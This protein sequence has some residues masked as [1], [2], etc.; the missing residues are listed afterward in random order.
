MISIDIHKPYIGDRSGWWQL[1]SSSP[2]NHIFPTTNQIK[3]KA[4]IIFL[5]LPACVSNLGLLS[6]KFLN[7]YISRTTT[8]YMAILAAAKVAHTL[9]FVSCSLSHICSL[10]FQC[11]DNTIMAAKT[12]GKLTAMIANTV[13]RLDDTS[14]ILAA[15]PPKSWMFWLFAL[16]E[17]N[18]KA[19]V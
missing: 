4:S 14:C 19:W 15:P 18:E 9:H 5:K 7:E 6:K 12:C 2:N 8:L 13:A 3:P 1:L 11:N 16:L 17:L 10:S